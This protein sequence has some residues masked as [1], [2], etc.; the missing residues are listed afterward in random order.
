[1]HCASCAVN[2]ERNLS[3]VSGVKQASVNYAT[4]QA[5]VEYDEQRVNKQHLHQAVAQAG[6]YRVAAAHEHHH[7]MVSLLS[8]RRKFIWSAIFT[9]PLLVKMFYDFTIINQ[10]F[11]MWLE[12]A[13]TAVVVF[14]FGWQFHRG[15]FKQLLKLRA[16]MDTLISLGTLAALAYSLYVMFFDGHVYF[17]TAAIIITL[18]LLGKFLEELSKGRASQAIKKLLSLNVKQATVITDGKEIKKD[19]GEVRIN[20]VVLIKPGEKIPLDGE[21]IEGETSVDESMLTGESL[22]AEKKAGSQ[23]FGATV[24]NDGVIKVK[25]TKVGQETMLAQI[26]KLVENAQASKAPIQKLADRISGI[27][28]PIVIL[29]SLLT[30]IVWFWFL[31][32][33][34]ETALLNAIAVLVIACPCALGLATPTAIMVGS[35]QGATLGILIKDAQSLEIAH[36]ID[37]VVFDKTGTLTQGQPTIVQH[38]LSSEQIAIACSLEAGSEHALA[39]AFAKYAK[40]HKLVLSAADNVQAIR[41]QGIS[42]KLFGQQY[43]LGN[44]ELLKKIQVPIS[45]QEE[46][47]FVEYAA[48]GQTP[49]FFADQEKVLGVIAVADVIKDSAVPAVKALAKQVAVQML[50][51]DHH[52]VAQA[53]ASKLG[54]KQVIAEV[55][56]DQKSATVSSLQQQGKVVAFVGDGINDAPALAQADLGIAMGSGTDIAMEAGNIVLTNNNPVKVLSAINLS[57][58]TFTVIKQNLFLAFIYNIIAIPLAALGLLSPVI[59]AAAMSLSSVSVVGNSLRI[60]RFKDS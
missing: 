14:I 36:K 33:G 57:K 16:N 56:P 4:G 15:M 1:M 22:P 21:I 25:I 43:Y 41:G 5:Q 59:A 49:I 8:A 48:A 31:P 18:I 44:K 35:G 47:I 54:I 42:G 26:I 34:L 27:F 55:L 28:V 50:T 30:F 6:D 11:G 9:L 23:V 53:I 7:E 51:G 37:T 32:A 24:N 60:K 12:A 19:I 3:A 45:G 52:L 58:K 10:E 29:I 38:T 46:K 2:I 13:L 40:A 20:D 39:G 17:E